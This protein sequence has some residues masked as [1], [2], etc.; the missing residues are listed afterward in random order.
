MLSV[1]FQTVATGTQAS[2]RVTTPSTLPNGFDNYNL[3]LRFDPDEVALVLPQPSNLSQQYGLSNSFAGINYVNVS[4]L[5]LGNLTISGLS[6]NSLGADE[7]IGSLV[8]EALS[9][10]SFTVTIDHYRLGLGSL[11][12]LESSNGLQFSTTGEVTDTETELGGGSPSTNLDTSAPSLIA[13]EPA[14]NTEISKQIAF[15]T[16]FFDE[17]VLPGAGDIE[18]YSGTNLVESYSVSNS[19]RVFFDGS[20]VRLDPSI[21]LLS[22]TTYEVSFSSGALKDAAGNVSEAFQVGFQTNDEGQDDA[23]PPLLVTT[24]PE[25]GASFISTDSALS[26]SFSEPIVLGEGEIRLST[27]AGTITEVFSAGSVGLDVDGDRLVVSPTN[28]LSTGTSYRVEFLGNIVE[29]F[30]G[31]GFSGTDY[32]FRTS[33]IQSG[34]LFLEPSKLSIREGETVRFVLT[35]S[36]DTAKPNL[37]YS[38]SGIH[39]K[40][41]SSGVLN[42]TVSIASSGTAHIDFTL[43]KDNA[44]EGVE[45]LTFTVEGISSTVLVEDSSAGFSIPQ[46]IRASAYGGTVKLSSGP[47]DVLGGMGVDTALING[48]SNDFLVRVN[49]LNVT[50]QEIGTLNIDTLTN[51]ERLQFKD[52]FIA[53]EID[54]AP[55]EAFRLYKAAFGREPDLE[56]IG[57]WMH[58]MESTGLDLL[59]VAES[60]ID[61]E[62]FSNIYG[63]S[64]TNSEFL[65]GLYENV[66][67]REPDSDGFYWWLTKLN[68]DPALSRAQLLVNFSESQENLDETSDLIAQGVAFLPWLDV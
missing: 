26:F 50:V 29:D 49:D 39:L 44:Y 54:G 34:D 16:F 48:L 10:S 28:A 60:F 25:N 38:V 1:D 18:L 22:S 47:D 13:S 41:L 17:A 58:Q 52:H 53:L 24:L 9:D 59:E 7:V 57:Y 62:E 8:F 42:G 55:A 61:S 56:G 35:N 46:A 68:N 11:D 19:A 64:P 27:V 4:E 40:D 6:I 43:L 36:S 45:R 33:N 31:N 12:L 67:G 66:L 3:T 21:S 65:E 15:L 5:A 14:N 20:T 2:V 23:S 37:S 30:S 32:S 63:K 51:V